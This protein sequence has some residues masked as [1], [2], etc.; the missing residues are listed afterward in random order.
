MSGKGKGK[1]HNVRVTGPV[2][3]KRPRIGILGGEAGHAR[4]LKPREV[5]AVLAQCS[6]C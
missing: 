1:A 3:Q 2:I 4:I 6:I 5:A